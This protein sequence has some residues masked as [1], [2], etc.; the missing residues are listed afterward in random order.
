[1]ARQLKSWNSWGVCCGCVFSSTYGALTAKIQSPQVDW[2]RFVTG[3]I[4]VLWNS[5]TFISAVKTFH[6]KWP[7]I[8]ICSQLS[9]RR[10]KHCPHSEKYRVT[11]TLRSILIIRSSRMFKVFKWFTA[12]ARQN[13]QTVI[14]TTQEQLLSFRSRFR[15]CI[16]N[17]T[18]VRIHVYY[19]TN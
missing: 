6:R 17:L 18:N 13:T 2:P 10:S 4:V 12:P 14:A 9:D 15:C 16:Q 5:Q 1:M 8:L 19:Q 7:S 3:D 11:E